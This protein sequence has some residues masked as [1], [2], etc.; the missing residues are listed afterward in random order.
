M[1]GPPR[2]TTPVPR[3]SLRRL[4]YG[5]LALTIL[6]GLYGL[7]CA[8]NPGAYRF[9]DSVDLVFHEAGHMIFWV[10]GEFI[11]IL[12]GSLMQV[13]VPLICTVHFFWNGLR[14]AAT[15]TSFWVAQ[16]L[17]NVSVY[18]KDAR[19]RA[20]PLLGGED[21]VHDWHWLLN[22]MHLLVWDQTI[23]NLVYALGCIALLVCI[24]GGVYYSLKETL[25]ID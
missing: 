9:F 2:T 4:H 18:I 24:A 11:G 15:F 13:L 5:R 20:L 14:W 3:L 6:V 8:S 19:A 7:V 23:G 17:F 1:T 16:N 10:F 21:T 12:G 25:T 22:K